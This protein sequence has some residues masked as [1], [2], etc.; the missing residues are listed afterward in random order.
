MEENTKEKMIIEVTDE[1]IIFGDGL[2]M[3][4]SELSDFMDKY[5]CIFEFGSYRG[6]LQVMDALS[7]YLYECAPVSIIHDKLTYIESQ[8][9]I[10]QSF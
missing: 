10:Y 3:G 4:I 1:G 8:W 9:N 6:F 7:K 5:D 2:L